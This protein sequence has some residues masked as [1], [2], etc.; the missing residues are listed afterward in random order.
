MHENTGSREADSPSLSKLMDSPPVSSK[1]V[2]EK[3]L[4]LRYCVC[5][6]FYNLLAGNFAP[7]GGALHAAD[8]AV[9]SL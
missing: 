8:Y 5:V 3:E 6:I 7:D 2:F 9:N 4:F 1:S